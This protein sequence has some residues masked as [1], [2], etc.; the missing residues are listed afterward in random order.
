V[1]GRQAA[2]RR[3]IGLGA[4]GALKLQGVCERACVR[5]R[6]A[7][8]L[9]HQ[10]RKLVGPLGGRPR[11]GPGPAALLAAAAAADAAA[12]AALAR[13]AGACGGGAS[14]GGSGGAP[15]AA[16]GQAGS[17]R[18]HCVRP[19]RRL[20]RLGRLPIPPDGGVP[21]GRPE[22]RLQPLLR[23]QAHQL[24]HARAHALRDP[25]PLRLTPPAAPAA[26]R[27]PG[28]PA[29]GACRAAGRVAHRRRALLQSR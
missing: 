21:Q 20:G 10:G 18:A 5:C 24:R 14:G 29:G 2:H 9:R 3:R 11:A 1:H 12:A 28:R 8:Q 7:R 25:R 22:R 16:V 17:W 15:R 4:R 19:P 6:R 13:L 23:Q 26:A 27:G